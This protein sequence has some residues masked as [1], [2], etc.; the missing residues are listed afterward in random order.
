MAELPVPQAGGHIT[1]LAAELALGILPDDEAE[2]ARLHMR[3]CPQCAA[4]VASLTP[5]ADRL[6]DLVP[7]TEPP[8]GFD[9]RVLASVSPASVRKL[10][11]LHFS[12][13]FTILSAAA[14]AA[15]VFGTMGWMAGRGSTRH[16]ERTAAE[17]VSNGRSLGEV[18]TYGRPTWLTVSVHGL[19]GSGR[20]V[21]Q[22]V[23]K[24]GTVAT[25]GSFDLVKGSGSWSAPDPAG[26]SSASEA[27]LVDSTGHVVAVARF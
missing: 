15:I 20:V 5:V 26:V 12:R 7:G 18:E 25:M 8:L 9:R 22:V 19:S 17:L 4:E 3:T 11:R 10:Q 14:A 16:V 21:C 13:R 6:L 23:Y 24:N 1:D 27:R 2:S